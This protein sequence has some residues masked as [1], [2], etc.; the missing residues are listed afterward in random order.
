VSSVS[1]ETAA[2][3]SDISAATEEQ[4]SSISTVST[5][6][7]ELSDLAGNLQAQVATFSLPTGAEAEEESIAGNAGRG[8]SHTVAS[9]GGSNAL[10]D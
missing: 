5:N 7:Q 8:G 2:E 6:I 9:D 1:E 4:T 3:A 10:D